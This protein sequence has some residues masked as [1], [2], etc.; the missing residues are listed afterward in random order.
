VSPNDARS[1]IILAPEGEHADADVIKALLV[2]TNNPARTE[3]K[4]HI[5]AEI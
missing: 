1:I 5:V 3:R 4:L 2:L